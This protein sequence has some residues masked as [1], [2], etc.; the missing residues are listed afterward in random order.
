MIGMIELPTH[1]RGVNVSRDRR[2]IHRH[3][4]S[5]D[6]QRGESLG[7]SKRGH[8][9]DLEEVPDRPQVLVQ[10]RHE[11]V[12]PRI[13]NKVIQSAAAAAAACVLLDGFDGGLDVLRLDDVE[14]QR[15]YVGEAVEAGHLGG[16]ASR[17]ENVEP[18]LLEEHRQCRADPA[19]AAACNEYG[20]SG[21][22]DEGKRVVMVKSIFFFFSK[23]GGGVGRVLEK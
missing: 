13:A 19:I 18:A 11:M 9:V 2:D 23:K 21:G 12:A 7:K 1:V 8:E 5:L 20:L 3:T 14:G 15:C 16:V 17:S 10:N 4:L 6:E 22:H